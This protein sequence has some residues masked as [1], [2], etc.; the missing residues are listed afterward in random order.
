MF[1][2]T[3]Q[4]GR[5]MELKQLKFFMVASDC[6]S[7]SKAATK[8]YTSQPNVSKVIKSLEKELG[9][10]LFER[11][12]RGLRLTPYGKSIYGY[13]ENVLKNASLIVNAELV[14]KHNTFNVSTYPSNII[15]MLLVE[16]YRNNPDITIEHHQGTVEEITAN[17]A[18]G[19]SELGILYVSKKQLTAFKHIIS[20]KKLKFI[21]IGKKEACIYVGPNSPLYSRESIS[22]EEL[23]GLRFVRGLSDFFSMEHHLEQVNVGAVSPEKLH[24]TVYTNS[25]HFTTNLLLKTD[26]AELGINLSYPKYQ[27]YDIKNLRIEG[28]DSY[29]T[30]GYVIEKGHVLTNTAKELIVHLKNI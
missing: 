21:E 27:Q 28:E 24:S 12:S 2:I 5:D 4:G 11:T 18:Q 7:L 10:P 17:V 13:A 14:E 9:S 25:E 22:F 30:L 15:A 20:H 19:I 3:V 23:Y 16:L 1:Y 6:G 8:L 29:L 26:L